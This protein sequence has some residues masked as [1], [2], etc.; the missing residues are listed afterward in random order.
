[1]NLQKTTKLLTIGK[2]FL[3]LLYCLNAL[4]MA[5]QVNRYRLVK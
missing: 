5:C 3:Y 1:M 2:S 4:L